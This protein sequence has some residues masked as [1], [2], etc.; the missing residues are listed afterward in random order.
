M[1]MTRTMRRLETKSGYEKAIEQKWS[2][3]E[4]VGEM[5]VA[6]IA[7][8]AAIST[9]ATVAAITAV[10]TIKVWSI[11][12]M[13]ASLYENPQ[14]R[15]GKKRITKTPTAL[16]SLDQF[17]KFLFLQV[18]INLV[19][20]LLYHNKLPKSFSFRVRYGHSVSVYENPQKRVGKKESQK[21]QL[22]FRRSTNSKNFFLYKSEWTLSIIYRLI[23]I[24]L[25]A[26]VFELDIAI[27]FQSMKI[28]K[29]NG[30]TES[31]KWQLL[32]H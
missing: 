17:E 14:K 22:L 29:K 28:L 18:R 31:Q 12:V 32:F 15:V 9:V 27:L 24:Y 1:K 20:H 25:E 4:D 11:T 3:N 26:L 21:C 16:S 6:T 5:L 13:G 30:W 2:G 7:T 19:Y 8:V 23:M 10:A